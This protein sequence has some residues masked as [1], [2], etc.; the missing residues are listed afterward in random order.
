LA[1]SIGLTGLGL[2]TGEALEGTWTVTADSVL[3]VAEATVALTFVTALFTKILLR[4]ALC[5]VAPVGGLTVGVDT[6]LNLTETVSVTVVA[7]TESLRVSFA[8]VSGT[9]TVG[10]TVTGRYVG[11][12]T[13][14]TSTRACCRAANLVHTEVGVA[15]VG[16]R[17]FH[18]GITTALADFLLRL[19]GA[20]CV[21][22]P[23]A[24]LILIAEVAFEAVPVVFANEITFGGV[25]RVAFTVDIITVDALTTTIAE[26]VWIAVTIGTALGHT[27]SVLDIESASTAS[28]TGSILTT[29]SCGLLGT[30][31]LR[32][33][34]DFGR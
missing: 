33:G 31:V 23:E 6:A 30:V 20:F 11:I 7:V 29:G 34:S 24:A 8:I 12:V 1:F 16:A 5:T 27:D 19:T 25:A 28:I 26:L 4:H 2:G 22:I 10:S 9:R 21:L 17:V 18:I 13:V 15:L 3:L 14:T 32:V